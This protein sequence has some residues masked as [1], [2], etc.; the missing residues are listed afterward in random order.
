[1][2]VFDEFSAVLVNYGTG[3]PGQRRQGF[4]CHIQR[5]AGEQPLIK[6][7]GGTHCRGREVADSQNYL[8]ERGLS[9]TRKYPV[10]DVRRGF[11]SLR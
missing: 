1:M 6:E 9:L 2:L 5:H 4:R 7:F 10:V 3:Y 11:M 8:A